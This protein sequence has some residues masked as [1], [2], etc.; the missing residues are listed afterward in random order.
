VSVIVVVRYASVFDDHTTSR[1]TM[2]I[3]I[4]HALLACAPSG[5]PYVCG[6]P[7]GT[8][9]LIASAEKEGAAAATSEAYSTGQVA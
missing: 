5:E 1:Y 3:E 2:C 6:N 9:Y 8:M 7:H 4:T